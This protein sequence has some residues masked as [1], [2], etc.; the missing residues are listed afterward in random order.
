MTLTRAILISSTDF[1]TTAHLLAYI[2]SQN[3]LL[4]V[5]CSLNGTSNKFMTTTDFAMS[6]K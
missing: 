1:F 4:H 5:N 6:I 2:I 3:L